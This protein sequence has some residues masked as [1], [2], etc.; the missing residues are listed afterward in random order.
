MVTALYGNNGSVMWQFTYPSDQIYRKC[1]KSSDLNYDGCIDVIA[2]SDDGHVYAIDGSNG[3]DLWIYELDGDACD[4]KLEQ[5]DDFGPLDIIVGVGSGSGTDNVVVINGSDGNIFWSYSAS[6]SVEH[7]E[8]CDVDNDGN[9]DIAAALSPTNPKQIIMID[10]LT[11]SEMWT[12]PLSL[13]GSSS[14]GLSHGDLDDD[15]LPDI[16]VPGDSTDRNVHVLRGYDGYEIWNFPTGGE[17]NSVMV[18]N[19]DDVS[20][21]EVIVGSDD[22]NLYVLN[23]ENGSKIFSY[24]ADGDVMDIETG[25]I[26]GDGIL[27]VACITFDSNGF[28][29]A[30][31]SIGSTKLHITDLLN[32]WNFVSLSFNQSIHLNDLIVT[33]DSVDFNW[34]EAIDPANGPIIDPNVYGWNRINDMYIPVTTLEPG[35]GYW[36]YSYQICSFGIYGI[37]I[38]PDNLISDLVTTWNIIGVPHIEPV[39]LNDLIFNYLGTDYTW[40]EATDPINGPI[41]DPNVYGWDRVNGMY[42]PVTDTLDPGYAYWMYSYQ[43]CTLKKS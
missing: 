15:S 42:I 2:G 33:F 37:T 29:Y 1:L 13:S 30:F 22:Q 10:G 6:S 43:D 14:H 40:L 19:V 38:Y 25:D 16:V 28:V 21:P 20:D 24:S 23:G 17:V 9:F 35:F 34:T 3:S 18:S 41:V 36:I 31:K 8:V 11:H 12:K 5:M 27:N 26:S 7:V 4:V 32:N 39:N